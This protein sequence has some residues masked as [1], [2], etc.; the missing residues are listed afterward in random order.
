VAGRRRESFAERRER[1]AAVDDPELVLNAAL[2][3]L[4]ARSRSVSEVRRRLTQAGYQGALIDGAIERLVDLRMLDDEGFA[5]A[6]IESRDRA[7]PRGE[8]A[9]RQEL[10]VKGIERPIIDRLL[11]ARHGE[12]GATE[13]D[14]GAAATLLERHARTLDREPDPRRRR[15]KAYALVARH[16][17]DAETCGD[18][19]RRWEQRAGAAASDGDGL[20]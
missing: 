8:R 14:L 7:R 4:E 12:D 18:A 13:R 20:P 2:R 16:G 11:E 15:Q 19:V 17:F 5:Q 3:F 6:W 1:R 10:A 9:L